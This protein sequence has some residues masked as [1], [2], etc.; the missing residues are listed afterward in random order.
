MLQIIDRFGC[1]FCRLLE[2]RCS[3]QCTNKFLSYVGSWLH[4]N[5]EFVVEIFKNVNN[6]PKS[7]W[8]ILHLA[9]IKT[10]INS[11]HVAQ[12]SSLHPAGIT[13]PST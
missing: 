7:L 9:T 13:L 10:V 12:H 2:D 1:C 3:L 8:Q 4:K 11:S 6:Q 5:R